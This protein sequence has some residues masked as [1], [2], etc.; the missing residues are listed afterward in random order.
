MKQVIGEGFIVDVLARSTPVASYSLLVKTVADDPELDTRRGGSCAATWRG[1]STRSALRRRS[2]STTS[3]REVSG[4]VL[5]DPAYQNAMRNSEHD[6]VLKHVIAG[7]VADHSEL[8]STFEGEPSF[9][10]WLSDR[11]FA[12]TYQPERGAR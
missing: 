12:M 8:Y 1:T 2:W 7:S 4:K 10:E 9:K 6:R 5:A 11:I 3:T